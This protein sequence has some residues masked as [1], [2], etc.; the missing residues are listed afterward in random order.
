MHY[1]QLCDPPVTLLPDGD[2][3][4]CPAGHYSEPAKRLP[5]YVVTGAS[6]A[7]KSAIFPFLA[8]ELPEYA[9]FDVDWLIDP[10]SAASA[11]EPIEWIA[12]RDAWLSVA[13]GL[14]QGGRATVLLS[15][16]MPE[17]LEDL[18][19]RRWISDIYFALLDCPDATRVRRLNRRPPWRDH[20][21]DRQLSFAAY[22]RKHIPTVVRTDDVTAATSASAIAG[23]VRRI[24]GPAIG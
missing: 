20:D 12:F 22:L 5:L 14:A 15:T 16:F 6:G 11:P 9:V 1:C 13:H 3:A 4:V 2:T 17:Q 8:A 21:T 10:L 23:W 19:A 24:G 18:P 7:G